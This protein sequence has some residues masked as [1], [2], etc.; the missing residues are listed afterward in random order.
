TRR[1]RHRRPRRRRAQCARA[2]AQRR[3]A[4]PRLTADAWRF[5]C[6]EDWMTLAHANARPAARRQRSVNAARPRLAWGVGR[7]YGRPYRDWSYG[8]F[9]A[10][11]PWR[12]SGAA[13]VGAG[14]VAPLKEREGAARLSR[15]PP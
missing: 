1:R 5:S 6:G 14:A 12:V 3:S 7:C 10:V 8:P 13:A 11:G 2:R 9:D 15:P 4:I